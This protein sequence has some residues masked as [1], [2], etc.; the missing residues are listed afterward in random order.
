MTID[1]IQKINI[2][3]EIFMPCLNKAIL[4]EDLD[5]TVKLSILRAI[6]DICIYSGTS[7]NKKYLGCSLVILQTCCQQ[8]SLID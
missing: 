6:G 7:F 8:S 5:R 1:E 4:K 2:D 3:F